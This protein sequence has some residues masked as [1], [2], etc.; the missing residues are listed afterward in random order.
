MTL[1]RVVRCLYW[2]SVWGNFL[3]IVDAVIL[4]I[5]FELDEGQTETLEKIVYAGIVSPVLVFL[6]AVPHSV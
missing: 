4:D 5:V 1:S 2:C 6:Y 3:W